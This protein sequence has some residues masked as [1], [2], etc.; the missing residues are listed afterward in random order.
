MLSATPRDSLYDNVDRTAYDTAEFTLGANKLALIFVGNRRSAATAPEPTVAGKAGTE[1]AGLT[2]TKPTNGTVLHAGNVRRVT[3]LVAKTGAGGTGK[4]TIDF[5][6]DTQTGCWWAVVEIDGADLTGTAAQAI[7]QAVSAAASATSV[8][9]ALAAAGHADN[10][11]FAGVDHSANEA[12]NPRASWTELA[13]VAGSSANTGGEAQWRSDQFETTA[14]G[15]WATSTNGAILALEVKASFV[16]G[17]ASIS[18]GGTSTATGEKGGAAAVS[19]SGGGT[20]SG[21][22]AKGGEGAA[23]LAGGGG[24]TAIVAKGGEGAAGATGGG[25]L[26][27]TIAKGALGVLSL[28]GGGVVTAT[29]LRSSKPT[30]TTRTRTSPASGRTTAGPGGGRTT[31]QLGD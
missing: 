10:R 18:G 28:L 30:Q 26:I 12:T 27:V 21:S 25:S 23:S 3:A 13:D 29:G 8:S 4:L 7:V 22:A 9:A 17:A 16:G 1:L 11:P 6:G 14:S 5:A 24:A 20:Q 2:F 31:T 15:S 19:V